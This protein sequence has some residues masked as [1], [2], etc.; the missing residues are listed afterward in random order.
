MKKPTPETAL[1]TFINVT[2]RLKIDLHDDMSWTTISTEILKG[3]DLI[4]QKEF[5]NKL[6]KF[7]RVFEKQ[8]GHCHKGLIYWELSIIWLQEGDINQTI[9][10]LVKSKNEDEER[11][12][13]AFTASMALLSILYPLFF[14]F[15]NSHKS[16]ITKEMEELYNSL[17]SEE[18]L[19]F[20]NTLFE[21]HNNS[22]QSKLV[23]ILPD[24]FTFLID[25]K[26]R[27]IVKDTYTEVQHILTRGPF[28]SYYTSIFGVGSILEA[29]IDDLFTR[30]G[31][32][33]WKIFKRNPIVL[34]LIKSD[35]DIFHS[36]DYPLQ[37]TLNRKIAALRLMAKANISPVPNSILLLMT[38]IGE[39]RDLIHPRRRLDFNF[40][41]NAYVALFLFSLLSQIASHFWPEN[42]EKLLK[43][44]I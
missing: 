33:F 6:D 37:T 16:T 24:Y 32:K 26:I 25:E 34:K 23:Y 41:A 38:L 3:T 44:L 30:D 12:L 10:Y 27:K 14:R 19:Q 29:M 9:A 35:K 42:T 7:F 15:S 13:N 2:S 36:T 40:E 1:K 31:E 5:W 4:F 43:K 17:T 8:N 22:S 21:A 28:I 18:K 39:Y 11:N 20:A